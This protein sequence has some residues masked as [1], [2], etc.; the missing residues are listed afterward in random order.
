MKNGRLEIRPLKV[1]A[2]KVGC[3]EI[4]AFEDCPFQI[5]ETENGQFKLRVL[6]NRKP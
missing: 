5:G 1:R 2:L 3:F 6:G 4:G